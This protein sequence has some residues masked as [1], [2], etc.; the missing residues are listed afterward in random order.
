[1]EVAPDPAHKGAGVT[2]DCALMPEHAG[3]S[4]FDG[5]NGNSGIRELMFK[6]LGTSLIMDDI[7]DAS[8]GDWNETIGEDA[9]KDIDGDDDF[10]G[11]DDM[12]MDIARTLKL[13]TDSYLFLMLGVDIEAI[14]NRNATDP[15][16]DDRIRTFPGG[17]FPDQPAAGTISNVVGDARVSGDMNVTGTTSVTGE[18]SGTVA[19]VEAS[20]LRLS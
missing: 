15:A 1:M 7:T 16:N 20:N 4:A 2:N 13:D 3:S 17:S 5:P 6:R 10:H 19:N 8:S 14:I 9:W 12:L 11:I 18:S